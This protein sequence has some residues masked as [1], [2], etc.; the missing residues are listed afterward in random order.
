MKEKILLVD[1]DNGVLESVTESLSSN[2][3]ITTARSGEEAIEIIKKENQNLV[4]LDVKLAGIDGIETLGIIK[5]IDS[6]IP[7]IMLSAV[8]TINTI[9]RAIK[10]GA[11]NYFDKP[12]DI[13]ELQNAVS[14]ALDKGRSNLQSKNQTLPVDIE[15][16]IKN[17]VNDI[18]TEEMQLENALKKFKDKYTNFVF[19]KFMDKFEKK[20]HN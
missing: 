18:L 10:L 16:F 12:F 6:T 7:V 14:E 1:D 5:K 20:H 2:Y 8:D 4:I 19:S 3:F 15:V 17:S 11:C 9:T 13:D